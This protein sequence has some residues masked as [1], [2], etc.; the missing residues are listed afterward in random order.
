MSFLIHSAGT[1]SLIVDQGRP[2]SRGLGLPMGGAADR[3][4]FMLGNALVGNA[5]DAPALEIALAGPIL[6]ATE[7]HGVV[8]YGAPFSVRVNDRPQPVGKTFTVHAGDVLT[9][10]TTELGLRAYLCVPGGFESK[11][12]M[13][14]RSALAPIRNGQALTGLPSSLRSRWLEPLMEEG[15]EPGLLRVLPGTHAG[16][17]PFADFLSRSYTVAAESN[18]MGLRLTGE[19]FAKDQGELLSAPVCPG[20]VQLTHDGLPVVLGIDAQ[21]IGGY[22]RIAQVIAADLDRLAQLRP[23]SPVRFEQVD[24]A[25]ARELA[26]QRQDRL[27]EWTARLMNSCF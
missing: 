9:I 5:P 2:H 18:R 25:A 21:T 13:G 16:Q 19:R 24:L 3:F 6:E 15:E 8:V 10:G 26:C 20:T 23:G 27:R 22:P 12:I 17:F 1:H 7:D 14:S 11:E 4:R